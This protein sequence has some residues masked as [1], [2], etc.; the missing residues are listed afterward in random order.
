MDGLGNPVDFVLSPGQ[1]HDCV[2][3][4]LIEGIVADYW[5]ADR[6]YGSQEILEIIR[7][8]G[9]EV[10]IPPKKNL[11]NPWQYDKQLYRERNLVERFFN[12]LKHFRGLA[13]RYAKTANSYLSLL[14][15]VASFILLQ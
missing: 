1:A 7:A 15:I 14:F 4:V 10:V 6:A 12:R 13:T 3:K 5:L 9:A 2:G 8:Q 11:K